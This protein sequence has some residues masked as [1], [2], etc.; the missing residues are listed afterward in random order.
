MT[1]GIIN[2]IARG[3]V[4]GGATGLCRGCTPEVPTLKCHLHDLSPFRLGP[5][6]F[7][8]EDAP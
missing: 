3:I 2:A 5:C 1:E 7:A 8:A 6:C 4:R